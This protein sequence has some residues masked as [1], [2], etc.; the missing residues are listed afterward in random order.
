MSNILCII[1][2]EF[3]N[4][5]EELKVY[6]NFNPIP[7]QNFDEDIK[8]LN[9]KVILI[10][11]NILK[12][13]QVDLIN[14]LK[15]KGKILISGSDKSS[16]ISYDEKI[17]LPLNILELNNRIKQLITRKE[18]VHN[19][20]INIKEY[21]LDKNEKKLKKDNSFIVVTEKEIQLLELLF[22]E[23]IPLPKNKI[24][25]AVWN[26]SPDAD[27]HTVETH[28]YRLRNKI[29]KEFKDESLIINT[30]QGYTIEKEK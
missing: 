6:L 7:F 14:Q 21:I 8:S 28:I 29:V 13:N 5:L 22:L 1:Q 26:Y 15:N 11:P 3:I 30:K 10:Q 12:K 24:L 27:T 16:T 23:N 19:S 18:F 20:S 4:S 25:Q 17:I 9:Y 2:D